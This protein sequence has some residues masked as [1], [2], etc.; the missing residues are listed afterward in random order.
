M[1]ARKIALGW[2]HC[3]FNV[4]W[5]KL[6]K[7]E[8]TLFKIP[9]FSLQMQGIHRQP[10]AGKPLLCRFVV[11]CGLGKRGKYAYAQNELGTNLAHG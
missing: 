2:L 7:S 3:E 9:A 5:N 6:K 8:L 11:Y 10:W 1:P 4:Y